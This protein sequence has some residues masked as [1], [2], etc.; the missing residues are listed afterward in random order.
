V[1]CKESSSGSVLIASD[2]YCD[3]L[4]GDNSDDSNKQKHVPNWR[5]HSISKKPQSIHLG[6]ILPELQTVCFS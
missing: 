3:L 4:I 2:Y 6:D 5:I 1:D